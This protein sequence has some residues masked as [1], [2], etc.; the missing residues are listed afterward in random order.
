[1]ISIGE[2]QTRTEID[3]AIALQL[4]VFC[5]EQGIAKDECLEGNDTAL[6]LVARDGNDVVATARLRDLGSQ[7][8][9]VARIAVLP[10]YRGRGI[11]ARLLAALDAAAETHGVRRLVMHPHAHLEGFYASLGYSVT[12]DAAYRIGDHLIITMDKYLAGPNT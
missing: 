2:A 5:D 3:A 10:A 9:E 8:A 11:A 1:M 12:D 7:V 6:I 4:R